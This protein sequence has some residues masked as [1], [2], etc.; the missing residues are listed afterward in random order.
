MSDFVIQ[1]SIGV[2]EFWTIEPEVEIK[3]FRVNRPLVL[4]FGNFKTT[5]S[6]CV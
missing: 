4:E 5:A 1:C 3:E 6:L 2:K